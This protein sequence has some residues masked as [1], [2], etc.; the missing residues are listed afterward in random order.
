MV[1]FKKDTPRKSAVKTHMRI[2]I[3]KTS[4]PTQTTPWGEGSTFLK[5]TSNSTRT[6]S[7]NQQYIHIYVFIY[8]YVYTYIYMCICTYTYILVY[9]YTTR[10]RCDFQK[11]LQ[12]TATHRNTPEYTHQKSISEYLKKNTCE[13]SLWKKPERCHWKNTVSPPRQRRF[14]GNQH[15]TWFFV[16]FGT[17]IHDS[18]MS[19]EPVSVTNTTETDSKN[20]ELHTLTPT[21]II[22]Y[23]FCF[24]FLV[25][26]FFGWFHSKIRLFLVVIDTFGVRESVVVVFRKLGARYPIWGCGLVQK[27][28]HVRDIVKSAND[29]LVQT[30]LY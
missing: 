23:L 25:F 4:C 5:N 1:F 26:G 9:V 19:S 22:C 2:L 17:S 7:W 12:H 15:F 21:H 13:C 6:N 30:C 29:H 24:L 10:R 16:R 8:I 3:T 18:S 28:G 14:V 11:R 27:D 20:F